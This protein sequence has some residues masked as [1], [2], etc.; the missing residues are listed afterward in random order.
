MNVT[1]TNECDLSGDDI[2]D[3]NMTGSSNR[4]EHTSNESD[5]YTGDHSTEHNGVIMHE[6]ATVN[7]S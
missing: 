5:E 6:T 2:L 1:D 3:N 4:S 7:N